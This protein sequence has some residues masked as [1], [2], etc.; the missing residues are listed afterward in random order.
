MF[1]K[2]EASQLRQ[3][4]WTT[5]GQYLSPVYSSE[6]KKINWINYRSGVKYISF[7]MYAGEEAA[8]IAIEIAHPETEN[9]VNYFN[10]FKTLKAEFENLVPGS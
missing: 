5:L 6:N 8:K 3:Q 1:S 4:F 7:K 10:A 9:R 2:Q